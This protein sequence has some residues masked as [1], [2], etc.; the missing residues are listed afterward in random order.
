VIAHGTILS[1]ARRSVGGDEGEACRAP[2]LHIA[3]SLY[4]YPP[5]C[6]GRDHGR[7][8]FGGMYG[9]GR[10]TREKTLNFPREAQR[11]RCAYS[12]VGVQDGSNVPVTCAAF[13]VRSARS[14]R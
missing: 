8:G 7:N 11:G 4:T 5:R 12:V 14:G 1:R 10:E 9:F 6:A 2:T 13:S 3:H